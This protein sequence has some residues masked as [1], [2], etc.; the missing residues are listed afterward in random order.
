M[1]VKTS[2]SLSS[3][4]SLRSAAHGKTRCSSPAI[5]VSEF[6]SKPFSWKALGVDVRGRS[7]TLRIN[8]R[9]SHQIRAQAD[10]L[11]GPELSD[12]D[13]ITENRRGTT[14]TFNGP[15][16][17]VM[18]TPTVD[19]EVDAARKWLATRVKEGAA[20]GEIGVFVRSDAQV[21]RA[22]RALEGAGIPYNVLDERLAM[23][24]SAAS[25]STMHLA[26]GL[27]FRTVAVLGCDDDIIP[28]RERIEAIGDDADLEEVYASE[29]HLLYVRLYTRSD[30][31]FVSG[32]RR[33][34]S[35][36]R[37]SVKTPVAKVTMAP[38]S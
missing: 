19:D 15:A 25:I 21:D 18:V 26:K 35:F 30:H 16:P 2:A 36:L 8:Y 38:R 17:T 11:L 1:K 6:S 10:R 31:L 5:S 23:S 27:E 28:L 9:T 4:F 34:Q 33:G 12:V 24:S 3:G 14:S 7:Y 13:G 37:I 20:P 29:R 32:R 22:R